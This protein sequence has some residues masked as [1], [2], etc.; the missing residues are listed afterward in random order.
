[1]GELRDTY[2]LEVAFSSILQ[3]VEWIGAK[4]N[5]TFVGGGGGANEQFLWQH[6]IS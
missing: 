5:T 4:C 6:A 1:M 2:V 3:Q